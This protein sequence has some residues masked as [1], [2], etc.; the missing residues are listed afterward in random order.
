M[1]VQFAS[2]S[3]PNESVNFISF[4][5]QLVFQ[6]S[7][8]IEMFSQSESWKFD[9]SGSHMLLI[10]DCTSKDPSCTNIQRTAG[11]VFII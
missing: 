9:F 2:T 11:V 8:S 4:V 3:F 10:K 5:F 1:Y 6:F 7:G